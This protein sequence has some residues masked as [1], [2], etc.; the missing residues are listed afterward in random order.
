MKNF[1]FN[2]HLCLRERLFLSIVSKKAIYIENIRNNSGLRNFELNLFSL[3]DKITYN[4]L[5]EINESGTHIKF[6]PGFLK[7]GNYFHNTIGTR[8]LSYYLEFLIYIIPLLKEKINIKLVGIRS[9]K[10]DTSL[11][12]FAYVNMAFFR[13]IAGRNFRMRIMT[14]LISKT[15]NTEVFLFCP[16]I[17]SMDSFS[18]NKLGSILSFHIIFTT[19][20]N[21]TLT[22]ENLS[23]I[24]PTNYF[25]REIDFKIHNFKIFNNKINFRTITILAETSTGCIL[26]SDSTLIDRVNSPNP[27]TEFYREIFSDFLEQLINGNCID[28]QR[29]VFFLVNIINIDSKKDAEIKIKKLTLSTI[30]FLRD[31]RYILGQIF[32]IKYLKDSKKIIIKRRNRL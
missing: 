8:A 15:K 28:K 4:S 22:Y 2:S 19:S 24:L 16:K 30:Y 21:L 31:T 25:E 11:E 23:T 9:L 10:A 13:K 27:W 18:L 1:V 12:A 6:T 17:V 32:K 5:F 29:Q 3:I 26:S 20:S 14:N 7:H